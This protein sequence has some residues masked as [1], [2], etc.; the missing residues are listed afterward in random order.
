MTR[1]ISPPNPARQRFL[2]TAPP[3][4]FFRGLPPIRTTER[5]AKMCSRRYVLIRHDRAESKVRVR[6]MS[7]CTPDD[8]QRALLADQ[9]RC[10]VYRRMNAG[11]TSAPDKCCTLWNDHNN[12]WC[13]ACEFLRDSA[14]E[15]GGQPALAASADN[16]RLPSRFRQSSGERD[17]RRCTLPGLRRHRWR[18]SP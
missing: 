4:E 8:C 10:T 16:Q 12:A 15:Q 5:G 17:R 3:T 18:G 7:T 11:W 13:K 2:R 1:P 14:E 9:P 6:L